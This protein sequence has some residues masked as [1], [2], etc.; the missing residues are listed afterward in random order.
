MKVVIMSDTHGLEE[1]IQRIYD[2]FRDEAQFFVHCGDSEL[3]HDHPF[4]NGFKVVKGNVDRADSGFPDQLVEDIGG[5]KWLVVHGHQ[6]GV[7]RTPLNLNYKAETLGARVICF[8]HTHMA[9]VENYD[10]KVFINPGSLNSPRDRVEKTFAVCEWDDI[11]SPFNVDFYT[12]S[13][14]QMEG[15]SRSFHF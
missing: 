7:H 2:R 9:G 13:V 14:E 1:V 10:G 6:D 15:L 11:H 8:G 4:L 12:D 3:S 5:L